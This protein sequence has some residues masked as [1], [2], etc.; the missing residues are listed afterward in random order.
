MYTV[1]NNTRLLYLNN[2][3]ICYYINFV[4]NLYYLYCIYAFIIVRVNSV[5]LQTIFIGCI[6]PFPI[7]KKDE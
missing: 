3:K 6:H 7:Y 1:I 2:V 5:I 4:L